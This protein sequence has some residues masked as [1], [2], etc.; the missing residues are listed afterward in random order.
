[1]N[2]RTLEVISRSYRQQTDPLPYA[3]TYPPGNVDSLGLIEDWSVLTAG[4]RVVVRCPLDVSRIGTVDEVSKDATLIWIWLDGIGRILVIE[5][6][7]ISI[8]AM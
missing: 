5:D 6:D 7:G 3:P 4:T 8:S 2:A 1:M